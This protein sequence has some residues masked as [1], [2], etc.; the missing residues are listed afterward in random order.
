MAPLQPDNGI[1]I[2]LRCSKLVQL[3][4]A[5]LVLDQTRAILVT[6]A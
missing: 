4:C 6:A 3:R 2:S 1:L 5:D